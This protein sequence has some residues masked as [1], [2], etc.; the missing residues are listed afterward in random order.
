MSA[1]NHDDLTSVE[2]SPPPSPRFQFS[3]R[4]LLV[5]TAIVSLCAVVN[6]YIL[7]FLLV[8]ALFF[9]AVVEMTFATDRLIRALVRSEPTATPEMSGLTIHPE[10]RRTLGYFSVSTWAFLGSGLLVLTFHEIHRQLVRQANDQIL[11]T[12][13]VCLLLGVGLCFFMAAYRR[14]RLSQP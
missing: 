2:H 11:L 12:P 14:R 7:A 8:A 3:V 9:I 13:A 6:L 10:S 1:S 5:T 4:D